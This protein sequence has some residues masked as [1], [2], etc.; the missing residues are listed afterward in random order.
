VTLNQQNLVEKVEYQTT[1]SVV[2]DVPVELTYSDYAQFGNIQFPKHIVEKQ[3]GFP[4]LDITI[5]NVQPNAAVSLP[6]P[7]TVA[8]AAVPPA[9]P[10][11]TIDKIGDGLW[12]LNSAGTRSVAVEFGDH[13]VMLE[14]PTSDARSKVVNDLVRQTVPNKPIRYVVNTHAHYDHAGGLR[15][16]VAEGITVITHE[17]N[18]AFFEKVWARARTL[19]DTAPTSNMPMIETVGDKRVLSDRTRTVELYHMPGHGHHTGQL[20]AYLPKERIL[21]YGD[22]YNP[23]AGDEIRTPERGPEY[24][25]QMVQRVQELKLNPE[26]IAPVHGRVVPYKNLLMAFNLDGGVRETR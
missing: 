21:M 19:E 26:R 12:S 15:E 8:S 25:A 6:V 2:G 23:P 18:K 9:T 22:G 3:D 5:D 1:N 7:E 10:M 14:G 16:Y 20:I 24:A 11:A 4:T 17:S 13:I